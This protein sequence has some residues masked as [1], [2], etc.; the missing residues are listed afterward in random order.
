MKFDYLFALFCFYIIIS[1][2]LW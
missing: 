2:I 1:A